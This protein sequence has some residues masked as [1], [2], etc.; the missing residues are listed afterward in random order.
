MTVLVYITLKICFQLFIFNFL[1]PIIIAT[2]V[3][4]CNKSNC[5]FSKIRLTLIHTV[6][7]QGSMLPPLVVRFKIYVIFRF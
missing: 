1:P 5:G 4:Q 2:D 6:S 7:C 3:I